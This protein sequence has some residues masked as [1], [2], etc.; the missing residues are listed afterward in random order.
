MTARDTP[1]RI[2]RPGE[3][4]GLPDWRD[5]AAYG[6]VAGWGTDRWRWEFSRR[7]EDV[8]EYFN[9]KLR[10]Q[11]HGTPVNPSAGLA[12]DEPGFMVEVDGGA[13]RQFG[14]VHGLPNPRIGAQPDWAIRSYGAFALGDQITGPSIT[15]LDAL[16]DLTALTEATPAL[17]TAAMEAGISSLELRDILTAAPRDD[18]GAFLRKRLL[19]YLGRCRLIPLGEG[20]IALTFSL[21]QPL[22]AQMKAAEGILKRAQAERHGKA[23]QRRSHPEKWLGYLRTLDAKEDDASWSEISALHPH[24]AQTE[25]TARDVWEQARALCFNF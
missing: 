22:A 25:Q 15:P 24:T 5:P 9:R 13:A 8:R 4:W 7:R 1:P 21:D 12:F 19:A 3:R 14:Y 16:I 17:F 20:Q 18:D 11:F 6:D 23:I 2:A 10:E